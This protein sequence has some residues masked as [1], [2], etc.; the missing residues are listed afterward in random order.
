MKLIAWDVKRLTILIAFIL[1]ATIA[2]A[3]VFLGSGGFTVY[4]S[5]TYGRRDVLLSFILVLN[6]LVLAYFV[7]LLTRGSIASATADELIVLGHFRQ[8]RFQTPQHKLSIVVDRKNRVI[9]ALILKADMTEIY[10]LPKRAC[11]LAAKE[12]ALSQ[13]RCVEIIRPGP[14]GAF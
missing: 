12:E 3:F 14:V 2:L 6:V 8:K 1:A 9:E 11:R 4:Q 10:R 5:G 7:F 13:N